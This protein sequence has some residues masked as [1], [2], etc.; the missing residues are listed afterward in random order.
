M[1]EGD[2]GV[3]FNISENPKE[4]HIHIY[5]G[6]CSQESLVLAGNSKEIPSYCLQGARDIAKSSQSL[7]SQKDN[8][9]WGKKST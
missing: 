6:F 7:L 4:S 1:A 9:T 3:I 5:P 8:Q 2:M